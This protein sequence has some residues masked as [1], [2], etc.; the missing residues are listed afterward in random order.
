MVATAWD[1]AYAQTDDELK[2]AVKQ[3]GPGSLAT[4]LSPFDTTEEMF[5]QAKYIRGIDPQAW[6]LV[7][8]VRV[9]GQDQVFKNPVSGQ[10]TYVIKAEKAP[11]RKGAEKVLTHFGGNGCEVGDLAAKVQARQIAGALVAVDPIPFNDADLKAALSGVST[12]VTLATRPSAFATLI[13]FDAG[14]HVG[15]EIRRL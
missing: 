10:I 13:H 14:V 8:A 9:A 5:L 12:L 4:I 6:I 11:N 1:R 3:R 7:N 2:A 15:G